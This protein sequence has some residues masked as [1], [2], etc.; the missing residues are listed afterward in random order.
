[1]YTMLIIGFKGMLGTDL[2]KMSKVNYN[3]IG[4]D[5][6]ELDITDLDA[7]KSKLNEIKPNIIVNCAA[8]TNVDGCEENTDLA[9]SVNG[10]GVRNL[11]V[12]ANSMT[13]RLV[14]RPKIVHISTDYVFDGEG[15]VD[16][17]EYDLVN[18][19]SVYGKSKLM[20]EEMLKSFYDKYFILR[21]QWLYGVNGN[22]FVK[23]M[24]K[25]AS[26]RDSLMVV[27]DQ[28]GC[29]TYTKDL[30]NVILEVVETE[31][32]GIY[33]VS[34]SEK[35]SWHGFAKDIFELSNVDI[36]VKPCTTEEFPRPAHRPKYS[37]MDNMMLR[38][39][40]FSEPRNYKEAL[41]EYLK[42]ENII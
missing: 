25:L 6:D 10:I 7:V 35:T 27:D 32:Y 41:K 26:E 11:A 14:D 5:S 33:H 19:L 37:V 38:I 13:D 9:Y 31:K 18:P 28:I 2:Y 17:K 23:T 34:N 40:G 39:N 42:E 1:M 12:A 22:N 8:Y 21:T 30:C 36:E 16:L 20:G 29:P 15:K 3:V 4:L 24:L